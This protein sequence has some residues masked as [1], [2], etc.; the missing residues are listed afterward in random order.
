MYHQAINIHFW[1]HGHNSYF[2]YAFV[3]SKITP[4]FD[5]LKS[6]NP[7]EFD[8]QCITYMELMQKFDSLGFDIKY[9]AFPDIENDKELLWCNYNG[10]DYRIFFKAFHRVL[11]RQPFNID[12]E[13]GNIF[14][15]DGKQK[16]IPNNIN[17]FAVV[18]FKWFVWQKE[19]FEK[20][21]SPPEEIQS[22]DIIRGLHFTKISE[23]YQIVDDSGKIIATENVGIEH[24]FTTNFW[25]RPEV[26]LFLRKYKLAF[27]NKLKSNKI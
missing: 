26:A 12:F 8:D 18:S 5:N 3:I 17:T 22:I 2:N 20:Y 13:Y 1:D 23:T 4:V 16:F 15:I 14:Q 27:L 6:I 11:Q 25:T 10:S 24:G 9:L 7:H 19:Q 21:L